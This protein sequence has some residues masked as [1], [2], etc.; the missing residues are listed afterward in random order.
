M[1]S[2]MEPAGLTEKPG[3][4]RGGGEAGAALGAPGWGYGQA[5][6]VLLHGVGNSRRRELEKSKNLSTEVLRSQNSAFRD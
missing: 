3:G 6:H 1:K 2:P 5:D 4:S